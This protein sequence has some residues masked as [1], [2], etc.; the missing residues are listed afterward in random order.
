MPQVSGGP[1]GASAGTLAIMV[2]GDRLAFERSSAVLQKLGT[3]VFYLG[4]S[5]SGLKVKL[6]NQA[7]VSVYFVAV[8]EA[9]QWSTK[10]GLKMEDLEKVITKSWGDS[11][12]FRHFL[13]VVRSGNLRGGATVRNIRKDVSIIIE[14]ADRDKAPMSLGKVAARY[15]NDAAQLGYEDFDVS[16]LYTLLERL[17]SS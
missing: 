9:Y 8:A 7:L 5:G 3:N 6:F 4:E 1:E 2:G 14:S 17:E 13:S 10:I 11:P 15:L 12:V 16:V